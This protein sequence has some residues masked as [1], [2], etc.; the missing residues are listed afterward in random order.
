[1]L[2]FG[3]FVYAVAQIGCVDDAAR[4]ESLFERERR[5]PVLRRAGMCEGFI[6]WTW[7]RGDVEAEEV[8][9]SEQFW[10]LRLPLTTGRGTWGYL[11]LYRGLDSDTLML[12]IN[13]VCHLFQHEMAH[14]AERIL[15]ADEKQ[16][17]TEEQ[18]QAVIRQK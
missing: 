11:N 13:Y 6:R 9:G 16:A 12:D 3:E 8:T 17:V 10:T 5:E 14:A 1:M 18:A 7:E 2:E 15:S 4:N